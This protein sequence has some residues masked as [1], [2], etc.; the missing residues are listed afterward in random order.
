MIRTNLLQNSEVHRVVSTI[1]CFSILEYEKD[2]SINQNDAANAY[3]SSKMNYHKRQLVARLENSG[4]ILE[5]SKMQIL[6][7]DLKA[8]SNIKG[9]GDLMKKFIGSAVTGETAIKPRYFGNGIVVCEPTYKYIIFQDLDNWDGKIVVDDGLFLACDDTVDMKVVS[10]KSLSS[11]VLGNEGLFNTMMHGKGIVALES[12]VPIDELIVVDLE[13]DVVKIDGNMAIA[14][15]DSLKF[16]VERVT[17]TLA[18]SAASG[19]GLVNVY[20][21]TGRVLIAPV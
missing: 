17:R 7:G 18:G 10:R 1:G 5:A 21:G 9:A 19:E 16:T 6:M 2:F 12:P 15:S 3:F 4:I 11:A 8:T 13:N 14:W 20:R